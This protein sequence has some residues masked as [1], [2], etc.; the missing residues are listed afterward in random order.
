MSV[1]TLDT[2]ALWVLHLG[3]VRARVSASPLYRAPEGPMS[4]MRS[5]VHA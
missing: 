2:D 3:Y 4:R 5:D 1:H